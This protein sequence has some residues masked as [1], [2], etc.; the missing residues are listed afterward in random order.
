MRCRMHGTSPPLSFA[1]SSHSSTNAYSRMTGYTGGRGWWYAPST[2]RRLLQAPPANIQRARMWTHRRGRAD[3]ADGPSTPQALARRTHLSP[4]A[5]A[6]H[7]SPGHPRCHPYPRHA[8][9]AAAIVPSQ[10]H[11]CFL[12]PHTRHCT[13]F[14]VV[15]RPLALRGGADLHRRMHGAV[16]GPPS[17]RRRTSP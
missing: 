3:V 6:C 16:T 5:C 11:R 13:S 8:F 12:K 10:P 7:L 17:I 1:T 14:R 9:P 15:A 4:R 2:T